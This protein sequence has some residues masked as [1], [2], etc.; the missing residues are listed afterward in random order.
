M[1]DRGLAAVVHHLAADFDAIPHANGTTRRDIDVIDD[2]DRSG[3]R[4]GIER[5]VRVARPRAVKEARCGSD[6]RLE[7]DLRRSGRT[8]C[9]RQVVHSND[10]SRVPV[11]PTRAQTVFRE[12]TGV[13]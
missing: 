9:C 7:I 3:N 10:R 11:A 1:H 5:F 8:V 6:R 13:E 12:V 2:L 4:S